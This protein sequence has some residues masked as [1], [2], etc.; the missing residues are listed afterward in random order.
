MKRS[1]IMD[2][3]KIISEDLGDL[4]MYVLMH[5]DKSLKRNESLYELL[6]YAKF[7]LG[8]KTI[9]IRGVERYIGG[10]SYES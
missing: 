6:K 9:N 3:Y 4:D 2:E 7:N 5:N 8:L 10:E 1:G